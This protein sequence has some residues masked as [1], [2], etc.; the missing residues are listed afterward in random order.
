MDDL[1]IDV[2]ILVEAGTWPD[3]DALSA[4]AIRAL[5]AAVEV[6]AIEIEE[7]PELSLVFTDDAHIRELNATWRGKEKPTN[8][9]SFPLMDTEPGLPLPPMLGDIVLAF[10]TV[11]REA[12]AENKPFDHHLAHLIVHGL[13]HLLGYDHEEEVEAER[14]EETERR[15]LAELAIPDPYR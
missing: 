5:A 6:L 10:E 1:P 7:P 15:I 9:L 4:V 13:L 14:M 11:E 2:A 3:E 8:V 12:G